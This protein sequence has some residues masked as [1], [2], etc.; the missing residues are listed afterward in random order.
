[1]KHIAGSLAVLAVAL[2][3]SY[4]D[5]GDARI[6]KTLH[7]Q[8]GTGVVAECKALH[9]TSKESIKI[10]EA[11]I[12]TNIKDFKLLHK[13]SLLSY[14]DSKNETTMKAFVAAKQKARDEEKKLRNEFADKYSET[15][16]IKLQSEYANK[17]IATE[18]AMYDSVKTLVAT[19]SL[20]KYNLYVKDAMTTVT[21]NKTLR[22][23]IV[24]KRVDMMLKCGQGRHDKVI[25]LIDKV[26]ASDMKTTQ[27]QK[28][29]ERT[30]K[31]MQEMKKKLEK[32]DKKRN[33]A[34]FEGTKDDRY[35]MIDEVLDSVERASSE[36]E[37]EKI[38]D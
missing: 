34:A 23:E 22:L 11:T 2:S 30:T 28:F 5:S 25:Q 24:M 12:K 19:G 9:K 8:A 31:R 7:Q 27:K 32:S 15:K 21:K 10:I 37:D 17:L 36:L 18:Q 26:V 16:V 38:N 33:G 1:M 20:E 6:M 13:E 3:F 4:A 14:V 29:L 35:E